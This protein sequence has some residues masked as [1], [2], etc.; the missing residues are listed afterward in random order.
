MQPSVPLDRPTED[1]LK[2]GQ[3]V[4]ASQFRCPFPAAAWILTCAFCNCAGWIL[5]AL[6]QLNAAGYAVVFLLGLAGVLLWKRNIF[7]GFF[8][9]WNRAKLRRRFSRSFP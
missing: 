8:Q 1:F 6:H 3:S 5:S 2:V 9:R 4:Q 7:S